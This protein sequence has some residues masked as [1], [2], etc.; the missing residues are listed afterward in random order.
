MN[1]LPNDKLL[2][3]SKLK[4]FENDKI[5]IPS[6]QIFN[7]GMGRKHCEKM[8][9]TSIFSFSHNVLKRP[10]FQGC[11]KSG[12]NMVGYG[13]QWAKTQKQKAENIDREQSIVASLKPWLYK[14]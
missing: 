4:A 12:L 11:Q 9:V 14:M 13:F 5:N 8:V 3:W 10:L 7:F 6:N 2:D 1:S